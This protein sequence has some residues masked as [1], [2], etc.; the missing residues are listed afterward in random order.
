[1]Y[2][3]LDDILR[4]YNAAGYT[5][6]D[7]QCDG[8]FRPLMDPNK[9]NLG[10]DMNYTNAED[11]VPE[12]ERNNRTIK[13][14]VRA[15]VNGLPFKVMPKAMI[16]KLAT[17][18]VKQLNMFPA[19]GCSSPYLSPY[20]IMSGKAVDYEKELKIPFGTSVQAIKDHTPYNTP[21]PRTIDAICLGPASNKQAALSSWLYL[22][23]E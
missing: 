7:I 20:T 15:L 19:K 12:A 21:E 17:L 8:E 6:R 23:A 3:A 4:T 10:V 18:C 11:H 1:L 2:S 9:D 22:P 14:R 13:E 5:I 16:R